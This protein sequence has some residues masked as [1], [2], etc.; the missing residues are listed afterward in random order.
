VKRKRSG[1]RIFSGGANRGMMTSKQQEV[2][3]KKSRAIECAQKRSYWEEMLWRWETSGLSQVEFCRQNELNRHRFTYWK[4]RIRKS[5]QT[6]PFV[7]LGSLPNLSGVY[8]PK[9]ATFG[10][11][12]EER[13]R[14]EIP[15]GFNP[16]TLEQ[17]I[18]TLCRL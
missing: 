10:L 11:I 13:F 1:N 16:V 15:D 18:R 9:G 4:R 14:I 12:L 3:M 6:V 2:I 7:E 17:L 8:G 5:A